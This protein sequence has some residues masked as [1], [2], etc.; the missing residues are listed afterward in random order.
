MFFEEPG[1]LVEVAPEIYCCPFLTE[2]FCEL[3]IALGNSK[4]DG[5]TVNTKDRYYSTQ[6]FM[7]HIQSPELFNP[8]VE[9]LDRVIWPKI[10]KVWSINSIE[11]SQ[12][13]IVKYSQDTQTSLDLHTDSS[14]I[15]G[16]IK[17]NRGYSGANVLF[18]RQKFNTKDIP[19][20]HIML[21]PSQLTHPHYVEKLTSGEKFSLI[22]WTDEK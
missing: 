6:D 15:T 22:I 19:V 3:L 7:L 5:W 17:L 14:F 2:D 13:F 18:P 16:S 1:Q 10:D 8:I 4:P 21:F 12:A 9:E 11:V 20:G